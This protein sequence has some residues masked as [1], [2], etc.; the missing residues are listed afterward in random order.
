[1]KK[2]F[3]KFSIAL[4]LLAIVSTSCTKDDDIPTQPTKADLLAHKW[5]YVQ[6]E[7]LST[8][9]PTVTVSDACGQTSY[10]NF[11]S[12]GHL[13]VESF[14]LNMGACESQGLRAYPYDIDASGTYL[15]ATNGTFVE[16]YPIETL[17]ESSLVILTQGGSQRMVFDR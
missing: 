17:T 8:T 10:F 15:F 11:T 13:V 4:I 1:M 12:D 3:K 5:Y 2:I 6:Q 16:V 9:P 14:G 7:D